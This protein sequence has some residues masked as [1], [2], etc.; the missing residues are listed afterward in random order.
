MARSVPPEIEALDKAVKELTA[1]LEAGLYGVST[2]KSKLLD[3]LGKLGIKSARRSPLTV[4]GA[5]QMES[6]MDTLSKVSYKGK[7]TKF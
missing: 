7:S 4:G 6:L 5:L 1:A 2:P 3:L